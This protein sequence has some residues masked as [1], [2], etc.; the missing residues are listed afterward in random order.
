M[1]K[2]LLI[3]LSILFILVFT[4]SLIKIDTSKVE[5]SKKVL[6][7][8]YIERPIGNLSINK[9]DL[10]QN[11]YS[12]NS[13]LNT[14]E[15]NIELLKESNEHLIIIAAHSGTGNI[16]YFER[17]DELSKNDE[18]DLTLNKKKSTY[19]VKNYWEQKKDG[20]INISKEEQDQL[21]LTTC[22]PNHNGYQLI[23]N[24]IKKESN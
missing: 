14:V 16:A 24:S 22:S 9:I 6:I 3:I 21:I 19:I 13:K 1:L 18:I 5:I 4:K 17:L 8:S 11:I 15:K 2:K 10:N 23:V 7:N 20:Y 12:K